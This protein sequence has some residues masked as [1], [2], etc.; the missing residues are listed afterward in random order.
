[1]TGDLHFA[2]IAEQLGIWMGRGV[3]GDGPE[4]DVAGTSPVI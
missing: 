4:V 2:R 1:V 3:A